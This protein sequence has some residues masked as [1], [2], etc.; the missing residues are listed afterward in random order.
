[1]MDKEIST[2]E[3]LLREWRSLSTLIRKLRY[4]LKDSSARHDLTRAY[5]IISFEI[6]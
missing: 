5:K 3:L 6:L 1:M 2:S 4:M